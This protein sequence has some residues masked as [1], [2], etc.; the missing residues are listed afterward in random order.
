M[1][2]YKFIKII[3]I[4]SILLPYIYIYIYIYIIYYIVMHVVS[5][6]LMVIQISI[7][8]I[9]NNI[10]AET[11]LHSKHV[12]LIK[13]KTSEQIKLYIYVKL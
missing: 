10:I 8:N 4:I 5:T 9:T 7:I 11:K 12:G 1:C 13:I 3:F 2:I 6:Q